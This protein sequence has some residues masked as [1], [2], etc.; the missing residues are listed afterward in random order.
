[1][2]IFVLLGVLS[3]RRRRNESEA[4]AFR[5]QRTNVRLTVPLCGG[6]KPLCSLDQNKIVHF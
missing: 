3:Q 4:A 5:L 6:R 2:V 1:M